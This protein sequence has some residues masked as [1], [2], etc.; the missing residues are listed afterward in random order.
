MPVVYTGD[1]FSSLKR[2]IERLRRRGDDAAA[3]ELT[4]YLAR[5][6]ALACNPLAQL[7]DDAEDQVMDAV[8]ADESEHQSDEE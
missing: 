3:D 6:E 2:H 5:L 8:R 1:G 4:S 7:P